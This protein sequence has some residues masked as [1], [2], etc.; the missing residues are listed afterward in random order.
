M[1]RDRNY[2][3]NRMSRVARI[4]VPLLIIV[5]G[6]GVMQ[7]LRMQRKQPASSP[8]QSSPPIVR[9]IPVG[10]PVESI[11]INCFGTVVPR[12]VT[13]LSA[14]VAGHVIFKNDE[15]IVGRY[16][17]GN[18][19]LLR[20]DPQPGKLKLTIQQEKTK[21]A[22]Q[23][24][25]LLDLRE[26]ESKEQLAIVDRQVKI[27]NDELR[28]TKLLAKTNA[29]AETEVNRVEQ[30][31]L[32]R[33]QLQL[34]LKA[35]LDALPLRRQQAAS[36][37]AIAEADEKLAQLDVD[38]AILAAPHSGIVTKAHVEVGAFV[39]VGDPLFEIEDVAYEVEFPVKAKELAWIWSADQR[40]MNAPATRHSLPDL[41][42]KLTYRAGQ[43]VDQWNAKLARLTE[44]GLDAKSQIA[45]L[46]GSIEA[47]KARKRDPWKGMFVAVK[48]EVRRV[49]A[50][51]AVP[52]AAWRPQSQVWVVKD[53]RLVVH[54][55]KP[56]QFRLNDVLVLVEDSGLKPNDQ[57][58]ISPLLAAY[59]GMPVRIESEGGK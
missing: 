7:W 34:Q 13:T 51:L 53:E 50:M 16:I 17:A 10:A 35:T 9:V 43:Q 32:G 19:Q 39:E 8:R 46:R 40:A 48:M 55:V 30:L 4:L 56:I 15:A 44:R 41:P 36:R 52:M 31:L 58:V 47:P 5:A 12:R 45:T 3:G 28:R 21:Q 2:H 57:L 25:I 37:L 27:A 23:E 59:S 54:S 29:T 14:R 49:P 20:L 38:D 11:T 24:Q 22:R 6:V 42:L 33:K 26:K 1:V 18:A